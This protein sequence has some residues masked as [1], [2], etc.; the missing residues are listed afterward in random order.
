MLGF[1][2]T[3]ERTRG[4]AYTPARALKFARARARS[5]GRACMRNRGSRS[6]GVR[7]YMRKKALVLLL[8]LEQNA[9]PAG[10]DQRGL[11][12]SGKKQRG[13]FLHE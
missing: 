1:E 12:G 11:P 2:R 5:C 9:Q 8:R 6:D 10:A 3:H 4:R 13:T 7:C